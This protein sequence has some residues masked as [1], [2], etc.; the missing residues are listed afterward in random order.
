MVAKKFERANEKENY[1]RHFEPSDPA[2][3]NKKFQDK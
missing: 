2:M 3:I 1:F